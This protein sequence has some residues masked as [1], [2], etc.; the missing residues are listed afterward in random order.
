MIYTRPF[1]TSEFTAYEGDSRSRA[2]SLAVRLTDGFTRRPPDVKLRV[3]LRS[4]PVGIPTPRSIRGAGG[5]YCFENVPNG[6]YTM[7]IETEGSTSPLYLLPPMLVTIPLPALPDPTVPLLDITLSPSSAYPFPPNATLARGVV[8]SIVTGNVPDAVVST[9]YD[10]VDP[11]DEFLTM[12]VNIE[13]RTDSDGQFALFFR[14]L[15][16]N[17]QNVIITAAQG[18]NQVQA[19]LTITEGTMQTISLP[20]LP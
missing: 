1:V 20:T 2:L 12:P 3:S 10:Q 8:Q 15:P 16:A 18:G 11:A 7:T 19:P 4:V 6:N 9:T 13:T 5:A 17:T 14:R